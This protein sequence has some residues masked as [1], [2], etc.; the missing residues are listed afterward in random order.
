MVSKVTSWEILGGT[1]EELSEGS[2]WITPMEL[3]KGSLRKFIDESQEEIFEEKRNL[4][5][6]WF[7]KQLTNSLNTTEET[8][9]EMAALKNVG[10]AMKNL[11]EESQDK[12]L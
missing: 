11:L 12:Y 3:V 10:K 1:K 7:R 4:W 9:E 5:I 6:P 8:P 2:S